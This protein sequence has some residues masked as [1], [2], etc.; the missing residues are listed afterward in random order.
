MQNALFRSLSDL[1]LAY[2]DM[3][4]IHFPISL[5]YVPFEKRYPPGWTY[6]PENKYEG[7]NRIILEHSPL[8]R[9]WAALENQVEKGYV[10]YIGVCNFN[11]ALLMDLLSYARVKPSMLQVEMHPRLLQDKLLE[12]CR[13][14]AIAVTAFSPFGSVGYV[15]VSQAI[16]SDIFVCMLCAIVPWLFIY[17]FW[18]H[19]LS[20]PVADLG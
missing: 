3:Y 4:M 7:M 2:V 10:K 1:G 9:T 5:K 11:V 6:D 19:F 13:S 8:H 15:E 16:I 12:F 18:R 14:Q 17:L 20:P